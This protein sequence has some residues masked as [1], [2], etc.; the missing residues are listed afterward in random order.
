[1]GWHRLTIIKS[2]KLKNTVIMNYQTLVA[3]IKSKKSC[4][5]VGLDPDESKI[6]KHLL[7]DENCKA[8]V[9]ATHT[10]CVAFKPNTAF[11]EAHGLK[12]W[13][14]LIAIIAYIRKNYPK[15]FVIADAK[16]GDIGNTSTKYAQTFFTE[17]DA[18]AVTVAPYMGKDS[19]SPF[20]KFENRFAVILALTSNEGAFDFQ[21]TETKDGRKLYQSVLE[22]SS[23]WG[24]FENTMY[25]VGATKAEYLVEIRKIIPQHF[26]LVPG[27]GA[28]GGSLEEVMKYGKTKDIGLLINASRSI[29]YA[30]GSENFAQ[31]AKLEAEKMHEEMKGYIQ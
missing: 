23:T 8:I 26:L 27:V 14:A 18:H 11:F 31:A 19:V 28:Q 24:T 21:N 17:M 4:L 13:K 6:P 5:C 30:D 29:L 16:R 7:Q 2:K 1:M 25:V 15:H 10:H 22:K 20:L 9:D 3:E 12:G